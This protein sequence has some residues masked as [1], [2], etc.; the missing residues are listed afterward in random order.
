MIIQDA[1]ELSVVIVNYFSEPELAGCLRSIE[2][3][4]DPVEVVVVDN[5]SREQ[6]KNSLLAAHPALVWHWMGG[7]AGFSAACN[8]GA[9]RARS[10][11]LLFLNPDTIVYPGSLGS[12]VRALDSREY[13]GAILGGA[14]H[15]PDGSIQ[16]SCRRFPNWKTFFAGRFSLLTR[17]FPSNSWSAGYLMSDIG[18]DR[19][20][21]VDWVS[22]AALALH[23]NTYERLGGFD[24]RFFVYFEDVDL[25]RRA[26]ARGIPTCYFPEARIQHLIGGSSRGVPFRALA[27]RHRSMWIYYKRH[28]RNGWLDPFALAAIC[29]RLGA[30]AATH[31]V[32]RLAAA[33]HAPGLGAQQTTE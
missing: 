29:G 15:N 26:A 5:G 6:E 1:P 32:A 4:Q 2:N 23:K 24:E 28:L 3:Q 16:L 10:A 21:R 33:A 22:G 9:R 30:L 27:Y 18:H 20:R 19:A 13:S 7:N 8:A 17:L 12:L 31:A 14:M 25:C 11:R